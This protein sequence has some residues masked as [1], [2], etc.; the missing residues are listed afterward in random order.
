[1]WNQIMDR[2]FDTEWVGPTGL[3]GYGSYTEEEHLQQIDAY[4][5]FWKMLSDKENFFD[6]FKVNEVFYLIFL[7]VLKEYRHRGIASKLMSKSLEIAKELGYKVA[8]SNFTSK[9]S[10]SI[11]CSMGFTPIAE[12]D[13]KTHYRNYSTIPKEIAEI[14]DKV[15]AMGKRL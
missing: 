13:Y 1:M 11:A 4:F 6:H 3:R 2:D 8:F 9:Y 15:V 5:E 12:L 10:Y 14:H 7:S